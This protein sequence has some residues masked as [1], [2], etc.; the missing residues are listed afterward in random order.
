MSTK[1]KSSLQF[2]I[3]GSIFLI[4]VLLSV[5]YLLQTSSLER[6]LA[7]DIESAQPDWTRGQKLKWALTRQFTILIVDLKL[8]AKNA[9]T[10]ALCEGN[11]GLRFG[12]KAFEVMIAGANPQIDVVVSCEALL[13]I[14]DYNF[15]TD[16]SVFPDLQSKKQLEIESVKFNSVRL[17]QDEEWPREWMLGEIEIL[18]PNGFV[19]NQYEIQDALKQVYSLTFSK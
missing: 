17:Y 4:L 10:P 9:M 13:Q 3:F 14:P 11:H 5:H 15:V 16:L 19:I 8:S 18:G 1:M 12:F 2:K 6:Q 7:S